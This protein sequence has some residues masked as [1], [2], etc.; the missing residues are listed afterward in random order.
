M[1]EIH[2]AILK[3][4]YPVAMKAFPEDLIQQYGEVRLQDAVTRLE[5]LGHVALEFPRHPDGTVVV[6]GGW[7]VRLNSSAV[8]ALMQRD[9]AKPVRNDT[10]SA[11]H[12]LIDPQQDKRLPL[13]EA[14]FTKPKPNGF[15]IPQSPQYREFDDIARDATER[16][17]RLLAEQYERGVRDGLNIEEN[18]LAQ[19]IVRLRGLLD[20]APARPDGPTI[21]WVVRDNAGTDVHDL[22]IVDAERSERLRNDP[23]EPIVGIT[24]YT[25]TMEQRDA[26][27][28]LVTLWGRRVGM[29]KEQHAGAIPS[30]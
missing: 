7:R 19:E 4:C 22:D 26:I 5:Q 10:H 11:S 12:D 14:E 8:L 29:L 13:D 16:L 17:Q 15:F 9:A 21:Q 18:A 30:R 24:F 23:G 1:E 20:D 2:Y 28:R 6:G 27:Y 3:A 25:Y